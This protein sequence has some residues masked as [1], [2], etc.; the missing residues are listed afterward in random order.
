MMC[1]KDQGRARAWLLS[2]TNTSAV[3]NSPSLGLWSSVSAKR[4]TR[5]VDRG[6]IH[7]VEHPRAD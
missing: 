4:V 5:A 3:K 1:S 6:H 7:N 2:Q